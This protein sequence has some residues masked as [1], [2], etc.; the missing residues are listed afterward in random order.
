MPRSCAGNRTAR[1][2]SV[3]STGLAV[4][5][6][7]IGL[8]AGCAQR[9]SVPA[10]QASTVEVVNLMPAFWEIMTGNPEQRAAGLDALLRQHPRIHGPVLPVDSNLT[11]YLGGLEPLLPGMRELEPLALRQIDASVAQLDA[12]LPALKSTVVYVGPSLFTSNGQVRVVDGRPVVLIGLDVQAYA[13]R[14]LLPPESRHDLRAFITH[15]IL[16]AHH[17]E[18]NPAMRDFANRLFDRSAPAPLYASLWIEGLATCM[19]MGLDGD[20]SVE[21]ALMDKNLPSAIVPAVQ[22][23][24]TELHDKLEVRDIDQIGDFFWLG[25]ERNDIPSRSGYAVGALVAADIVERQ[26]IERALGLQGDALIAELR[27]SL[28]ALMTSGYRV[29]WTG[30]CA[31]MK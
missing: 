31:G 26:G 6:L 16:H 20:G 24:A 7:L 29:E 1:P 9:E 21:R 18:K 10:R 27:S 2:T 30:A 17:Y 12:L 13:E 22:K 4:A 3:N 15:E 19:S 28:K 8:L 5:A 14:D 25:R 11:E 23:V